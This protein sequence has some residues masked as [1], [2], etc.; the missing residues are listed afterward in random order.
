MNAKTIVLIAAFIASGNV[1]AERMGRD[2]VYAKAGPSATVPAKSPVFAGNGR[3]SVYASSD[4]SI[5]TPLK[6]PAVA[7][8]GRSSVYAKDFTQRDVRTTR[9]ADLGT[10]HGRS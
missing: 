10:R 3:G 8:N 9:Q 6:G 1:F 5:G 4:R 2:S 7:G